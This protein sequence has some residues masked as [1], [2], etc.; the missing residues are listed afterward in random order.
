VPISDA[1]GV[2]PKYPE[3]SLIVFTPM[4]LVPENES[5]TVNVGF[6]NPEVDTLKSTGLPTLIEE[7]GLTTGMLA[8]PAAWANEVGT[9]STIIPKEIGKNSAAIP[10]GSVLEKWFMVFF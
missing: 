3:Y 7:L 9:E 2:Q 4:L 10:F 5:V 6:V 8:D 1:I